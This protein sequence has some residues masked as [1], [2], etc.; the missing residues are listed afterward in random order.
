MSGAAD[1]EIIVCRHGAVT[2]IAVSRPAKRNAY[3]PAMLHA[4]AEAY[5]AFEAD[6]AA[7]V[8]V[9]AA[10][11]A[12]FT[13]G[14]DLPRM[15]PVFARGEPLFPAH[16]VDPL[17][18]RPPWRRK[19]LV[20]AVQ[21]ICFT[22]GIELM[23]AADIAIAAEDCRF[24]QLEVKRGLMAAGGATVRMVE[25]AGWGRAM[26]YLL[27]GGEFTAAEALEMGF[28]AEVV[29]PGRQRERALALAQEIAEQAP[30]AVAATLANARK[31]AFDGALAAFADL[32]PLQQ[33][34]ARTADVQEGVRSLIER[35]KANFA[36]R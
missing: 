18:L 34:L 8:A 25:R 22:I 1:G 14:L 21:G 13:G 15:Q 5:T 20:A 11:G 16:C 4:L 26:R 27:T 19:P 10:E 33:S 36:G 17:M 32:D 6:D 28:V 35:R 24:A 2:E 31:A 29:P 3:T 23:L 30:L 7:R 9:L 12:H